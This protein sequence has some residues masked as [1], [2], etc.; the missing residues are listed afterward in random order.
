[1]SCAWN[2]T[3]TCFAVA[4]QE[5]RV[6]VWD[7]RSH[8]VVATFRT[9][10]ACRNVKFSCAPVDLLV[11]SEARKQ[12]HVVDARCYSSK[13]TCAVSPSGAVDISGIACTPTV[14]TW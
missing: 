3:G 10:E 12:V 9:P 13:Q 2:S 4:S 6:T 8:K 14:R 7:H 1:M 5:G 11:F